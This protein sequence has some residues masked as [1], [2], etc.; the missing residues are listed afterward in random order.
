PTGDNYTGE[1]LSRSYGAAHYCDAL[2]RSFDYV[3]ERDPENV[4][5]VGDVT[6]NAVDEF[7]REKLGRETDAM[8]HRFSRIDFTSL[9]Q[10]DRQLRN[11]AWK[12]HWI[13]REVKKQ[14]G[15]LEIL[16]GITNVDHGVID[17]F[18]ESTTFDGLSNLDLES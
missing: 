16:R 2:S 3:V 7:I 10:L 1:L 6:F 5:G 14:L 9:S 18:R 15:D 8:T 13:Q 17:R 12:H 4:C 11:R